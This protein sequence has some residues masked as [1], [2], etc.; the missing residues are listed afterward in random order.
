MATYVQIKRRTAY[1][2]GETDYTTSTTN[3]VIDDHINATVQDACNLYPY[4]FTLSTGTLTLSSGSA[5]LPSDYNPKWHIKD[6]RI[7]ASSQNDD[8]VFTEINTVD[9]DLYGSGDYVYWITYNSSTH[10][11]VFNSK[12]LTGSVDIFYNFIPTDMSSDGDVCIIPD[13]E[14]V[15]YGAAS[16]MWVG[17]ERNTELATLY[18]QEYRQRAGALYQ[19]D[20]AFGPAEPQGT[21]IRMNSRLRRV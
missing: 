19:A 15:S 13:A 4:S 2:R 10:V 21:I 3:T 1:L 11:Y 17:D 6:A 7:T 20:Q 9:R 5:N 8:S 12:T 18:E 16:K 14:L